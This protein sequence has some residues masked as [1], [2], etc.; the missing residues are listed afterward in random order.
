MLDDVYRS[1]KV[2]DM[3]VVERL[4]VANKERDSAVLKANLLQQRFVS[5]GTDNQILFFGSSTILKDMNNTK[6]FETLR[7][8]KN[9]KN[10]N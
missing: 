6:Q 8:M 7:N 3:A 2:R 10:K 4:K 9:T 5:L 1:Q